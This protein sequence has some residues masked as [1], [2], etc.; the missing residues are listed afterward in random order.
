MKRGYVS[1]R[2]GQMHY[3]EAGRGDLLLLIH[4]SGRSSRMFL[5]AV[6]ELAPHFRTVAFDL[7]GFGN[8]DPAPDGVTIEDLGDL[9][10]EVIAALGAPSA[11]VYGHH[12]GNKVATALAGRHP[13]RVKRLVLAGQSHS[14]IPDQAER[15]VAIDKF[16][17]PYQRVAAV[18]DPALLKA[19]KWALT[20]RT[21]T[22]AWWQPGILSGEAPGGEAVVKALVLDTLQGSDGS[23]KLYGANLVYDLEAGYRAIPVKTLVLEIVTP[24]E[25][26]LIGRR[27]ADVCAL[28]PGSELA[29]IEHEDGDGVTLEGRAKDLAAILT[30]FFKRPG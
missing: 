14:I 30:G 20:Y 2:M 19:E 23:A 3:V 21:M 10:A 1:T 16:V 5:E 7:P 26:H 9:C 4:Q 18:S 28:I 15:N 27:G 24:E 17:R 8:S 13:G 22:A 25:D 12:S 29:E 11:Y 6:E